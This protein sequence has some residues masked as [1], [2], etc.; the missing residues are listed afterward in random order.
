MLFFDLRGRNFDPESRKSDPWG[1]KIELEGRRIDLERLF[2]VM[3]VT[4]SVFCS[5]KK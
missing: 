4:G 3:P 2:G 5:G 1:R